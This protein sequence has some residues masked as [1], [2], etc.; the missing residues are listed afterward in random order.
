V[1]AQLYPGRAIR[2]ALLWT[3]L[4]EIMELSTSALDAGL[5]AVIST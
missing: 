3:E 2:A 1:L 4:P 5:T